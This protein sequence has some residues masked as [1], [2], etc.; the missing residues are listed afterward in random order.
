MVCCVWDHNVCVLGMK[1][2][3]E[4]IVVVVLCWKMS[5][6]FSEIKYSWMN[7]ATKDILNSVYNKDITKPRFP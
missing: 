2:K 4:L 1:V 6:T 7:I 5:H 3:S